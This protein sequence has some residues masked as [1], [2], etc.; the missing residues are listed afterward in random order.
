MALRG[1]LDRRCPPTGHGSTRARPGP[2]DAAAPP[3]AVGETC[4]EDVQKADRAPVDLL[5]TIDASGSM[6][7]MVDGHRQPKYTLVK[8]ALL[9]FVRDPGSAGLGLGVQFFPL[10]GTGSPCQTNL[11]CGFPFLAPTPPPCQPV[12]ACADPG[13][14]GLLRTCGARG[15]G[16]GA[17][18]CVPLG[19]CS[20]S[21]LD[22]TN[23]GDACPGGAAGDRCLGLGSACETTSGETAACAPAVYEQLAVP[24]AA[25]PIPGAQVVARQL[26]IRGPDGSTPMRPAV[27]GALNHL[28]NHLQAQS[29]PAGGLRARHRWRARARLPGNTV[30]GGRR[31]ADRGARPARGRSPPMW[32]ASRPPTTPRSGWCCSTLATAG[33][34]GQ[35]FI[36]GAHGQPGP[37]VPGGPEPDPGAGP[38]LRVHHPPAARRRGDRFRQGERALERHRRRGGGALRR[39]RRRCD[40]A[41]GGWYYDVEPASGRPTRIIA[42]EATCQKLQVRPQASVEI[43]FGCR[44][45]VID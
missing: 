25:L 32:S 11:D 42:C 8:Q 6:G 38:A 5:L 1:L 29:G 10:P 9:H 40:P 41:G 18:A 35:P 15:A 24:I 23:I 30:A 14:G 31:A 22:C 12:R 27:E 26:N 4:A 39:R 21:L 20:V 19:R 45:R 36:I 43:R 17:V 3:A 2:A 37:A 13:A 28:R 33:G 34:T 7:S 44:T 16:C